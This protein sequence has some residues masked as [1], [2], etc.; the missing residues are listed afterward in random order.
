MRE[1]DFYYVVDVRR[2]NRSALHRCR[3]L[4]YARFLAWRIP[5]SDYGKPGD[6]LK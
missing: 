3:F 6:F 2:R 1:R 5:F 4:F